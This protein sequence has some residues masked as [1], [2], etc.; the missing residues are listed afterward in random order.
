MIASAFPIARRGL[1][2]VGK[3]F[4][5]VGT[6]VARKLGRRGRQLA[7]EAVKVGTTVAV[8]EAVSKKL[9]GTAIQPYTGGI[10]GVPAA[11]M[12]RRYR[13][14]NTAN[15]KALRRAIRRVDGFKKLARAVG[16]SR[17]PGKLR[18]VR[19]VKGM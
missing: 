17:P 13:R 2:L 3:L 14:M 12:R 9:K 5:K 7:K 15:V 11:A 6:A 1:P 8:T 16:F 18:G 10:G 19:K 4:K